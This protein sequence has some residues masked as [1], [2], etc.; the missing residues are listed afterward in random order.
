MFD[1]RIMYLL[2]HTYFY[3]NLNADQGVARK[4]RIQEKKAKQR[5]LS[6]HGM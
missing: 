4:A 3:Y 1:F 2:K 5:W 6:G